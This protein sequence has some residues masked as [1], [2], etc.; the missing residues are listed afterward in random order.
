MFQK[1]K[2]LGVAEKVD[3]SLEISTVEEVG[4]DVRNTPAANP[5]DCKTHQ[6]PSLTPSQQSQFSRLLTAP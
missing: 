2:V 3:S 5:S 1:G 6:I 4:D